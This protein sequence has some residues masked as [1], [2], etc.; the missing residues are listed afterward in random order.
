MALIPINPS[1]AAITI[2][3]L[4][5]GLADIK[6]RQTTRNSGE[7]YLYFITGAEV[8]NPSLSGLSSML[9]YP[10][11]PFADWQLDFMRSSMAQVEKTF[12]IK[13]REV[14]QPGLADLTV[15]GTSK[16]DKSQVSAYGSGSFYESLYMVMGLDEGLPPNAERT[17]HIG[18]H[19]NYSKTNWKS[20]WLHELGHALGLEHPWDVK[21]KSLPWI[22]DTDFDIVSKDEPHSKTIMGYSN[23]YFEGRN[24]DQW[25]EPIDLYSLANIWGLKDTP[26]TIINFQT[27][28]KIKAIE[29]VLVAESFI[30]EVDGTITGIPPKLGLQVEGTRGNDYFLNTSA[31]ETIDGGKGID[32]FLVGKNYVASEIVQSTNSIQFRYAQESAASDTLVSVE[33]LKFDDRNL[34]YDMDSNAG[35]ALKVITT[36][37][38]IQE[39]TNSTIVGIAIRAF[40][41]GLDSLSICQMALD[42]VGAK[43][44]E[45]VVTRLYTNLYGDIPSQEN[46]ALY[47]GAIEA[48]LYTNASLSVA[49]TALA[50]D[51]GAIDLVGLAQTG[52]EYI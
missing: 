7:M 45:E 28:E 37:L 51:L 24:W 18:S 47:V 46:L 40:D 3:G 32:T 52:V 15:T 13:I 10:A 6:L 38:G 19:T 49:A 31:A 33:R 11:E 14:T 34:A 2:E 20:I 9:G 43:T 5:A 4:T 36:I 30:D 23:T 50:D 12:N 29:T 27:R 44:A 35:L 1:A 22:A 41:S 26:S 39:V 21:T 25:Y 17:A 8:A 48:G 16:V 42:Y